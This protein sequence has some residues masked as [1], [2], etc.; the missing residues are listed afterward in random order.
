MRSHAEQVKV[1][2]MVKYCTWISVKHERGEHPH[3]VPDSTMKCDSYLPTLFVFTELRKMGITCSLCLEVLT[4]SLPH[5]GTFGVS[6]RRTAGINPEA[7]VRIRGARVTE[8]IWGLQSAKQTPSNHLFTHCR[9]FSS[10]MDLHKTT[11]SMTVFPL[12]HSNRV[13]LLPSKHE[14]TRQ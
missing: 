11:Q 12:W 14:Q 10:W 6:Y 5:E 9:K 4:P 3:S 8:W 1:D 2:A 13:P 7:A